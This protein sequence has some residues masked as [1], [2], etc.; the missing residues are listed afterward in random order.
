M[1]KNFPLLNMIKIT[2]LN[3]L[4]KKINSLNSFILKLI[5]FYL[6][7]ANRIIKQFSNFLNNIFPLIF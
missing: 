3:Q 4:N 6:F 5:L 7:K 2:Y 1:K